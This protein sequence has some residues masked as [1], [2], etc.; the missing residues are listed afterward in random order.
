[1]TGWVFV[2]R[3]VT[4]ATLKDE[5]YA[6]AVQHLM[7]ARGVTVRLGGSA[8]AGWSDADVAIANVAAVVNAAA[9]VVLLPEEAA[10]VSSVWLELGM[11]LVVP[12]PTVIVAPSST[13]LPFLVRASAAANPDRIEI[14]D[15]QDSAAAT[16]QR[17]LAAID[18][19]LGSAP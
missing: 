2:A 5:E 14:V 13:Q 3:P 12:L 7:T 1:M 15:A 8:P 17:V 10:A 19:V 18:H 6:L 9:L 4:C 16:A 11:A